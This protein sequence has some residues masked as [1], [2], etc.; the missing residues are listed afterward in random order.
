M[1]NKLTIVARIEAKKDKIELVKSELLKL[2]APT[3]N[4]E[5]CLQYDLH[6]DNDRPEV[7]L[8]YENW[9]SRELWQNHM[10]SDHLKAY[11]KATEGAVADFVLN[12]M[13]LIG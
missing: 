12:E 13:A 7:F 3:R 5:G 8:F 2:I 11:A 10:N 4:E 9:T 6:Q 1:P